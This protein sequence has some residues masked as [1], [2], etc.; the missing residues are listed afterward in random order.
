MKDLEKI[1]RKNRSVFDS[2]EPNDGHFDR[3][4]QKLKEFNKNK[5]S[6]SF[7]YLL[8]V[9]AIAVL[10][11][12]SGLWV[13]DNIPKNQNRTGIALSDVSP[14][15]N[16]VEM[17]YT[18]LVNQK[19][20][21]LDQFNFIDSTQKKMLINELTEMDKMYESLKKDLQTSPNDERVINAMI[22]HYRLKVKIMNQIVYQLQQA[23]N[24]KEKNSDNNESTE[25]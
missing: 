22:Q 8:K 16:E 5:K 14:E 21:E 18:H 13:F 15:Y 17:Y 7:T 25:I 1:I 2:D 4:E 24:Y 19:Y 10:V 3:F 12:L 23:K 11:L 6:F 20:N 9:A